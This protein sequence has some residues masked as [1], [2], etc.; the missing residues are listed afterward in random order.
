MIYDICIY[1]YMWI[2]HHDG[3]EGSYSEKGIN[4]YQSSKL[5]NV[6]VNLLDGKF[7][8][9]LYQNEKQDEDQI[10]LS[11]PWKIVCTI[12]K[13]IPCSIDLWYQL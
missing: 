10:K 4:T 5:I 13:L 9:Y 12:L 3:I 8:Y 7:E 2:W 11:E 1:M 6:T